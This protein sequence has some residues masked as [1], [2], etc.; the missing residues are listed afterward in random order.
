MR[1]V[2]MVKNGQDQVVVLP[3]DMAFEGVSELQ[4][5]KEGDTIILRPARPD[6]L[7]FGRNNKADPDFIADRQNIVTDEGRFD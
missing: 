1:T 3:K 5:T 4:I 7:S 6:W 2:S